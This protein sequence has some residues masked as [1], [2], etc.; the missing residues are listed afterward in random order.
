MTQVKSKERLWT[1]DLVLAS[2][3]N[4]FLAFVFYM[5]MT[6]M[7]GYAIAR[8]N[9]SDTL[10]GLTSSVFVIGATVAR[11]FAG[12]LVDLVGR[13][14]TLTISL[15]V[16]LIASLSYL[17]ADA[18]D[19]LGV[20]L[21]V[22]AIHGVAFAAASTAAMALAQSLIPASRRAEGTGYF[23][24][25]ITLATAL[26]PFVAL[27]LVHG[28]GFQAL[29]IAGCIA[30]ALAMITALFLRTPHVPLPAEQRARLRRFHPRD[31][32]HA[33]VVPVASFMFV[34][35]IS[36]S[37][38]LTFLNSYANERGLESAA[39]VF[40]LVYAAVVFLARFVAGPLQDRRGDN[41]VVY[42]AIGAFA[43][44]LAVLANA[45]S[46]TVLL[47]A[48][49]LM[50]LGYG[51]LMSALQSIAVARVPMPRIGVAISTHFFMIDLG[52]GIGPILLGLLLSHTDYAQMYLLLAG[53]V[54]LAAALYHLV[55]GRV[56]RNRHRDSTPQPTGAGTH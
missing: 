37:G 51:T 1:R 5:L 31:M 41:L 48:G 30:S 56:D 6:T 33:D 14:R 25:S 26:G 8:F 40:F 20:L 39:S 11:L 12:N 49:G 4:L 10:G 29:F 21:V 47:L 54:L 19:S 7:A 13:R 45:H 53:V 28:P 23:T 3:T 18:L 35:A 43:A 15:V 52:V 2:I 42:I 27:L 36:Y 44:G 32:L 16:F 50:G 24:L 17:P 46:N 55:H 22:R 34:M 38:V 9:A